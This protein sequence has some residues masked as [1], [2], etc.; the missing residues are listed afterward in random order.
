MKKYSVVWLLLLAQVCYSIDNPYLKA[1]SR[2][3]GK[4]IF[5]NRHTLYFMQFFRLMPPLHF[6]WELAGN[7]LL[8]N[9]DC[10]KAG[11]AIATLTAPQ[12]CKEQFHEVKQMDGVSMFVYSYGNIDVAGLS[13]PKLNP[14]LSPD[15]CIV[16]PRRFTELPMVQHISLEQ[17]A[18]YIHD[19]SIMLYTG[20]GISIACGVPSM[21]QLEAALYIERN[22]DVLNMKKIIDNA[23][24]A[25]EKFKHFFETA[26]QLQPSEAHYAIAEIA[27][28]KKC[29][30]FTENIDVGHQKSGIYP[31]M[32]EP[33]LR[34]QGVYFKD[35]D[36]IVCVGLS[37]DDRGLLAFYKERNP[38]GV[39]IAIDLKQ[40]DYLG[41][42]D[43]LLVGDLQEI[44]PM[45]AKKITGTCIFSF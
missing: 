45:L 12:D 21:A 24:N 7:Y 28:D 19:H 6:K 8:F 29:A 22:K 38:A 17:L 9:F 20:A 15:Y 5:Y 34:D 23:S 16:E 33:K 11:L 31:L 3:I 35:I 41:K 2:V 26:F 40:T 44:V 39:I 4:D 32:A 37:H 43:M 42:E 30:V 25:V 14:Q 36:A 10:R 1:P 13:I 18:S 27:N